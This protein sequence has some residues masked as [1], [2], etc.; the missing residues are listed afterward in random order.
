MTRISTRVRLTARNLEL[1][2]DRPG[3]GAAAREINAAA[4]ETAKAIIK[5]IGRNYRQKNVSKPFWDAYDAILDPVLSK[6]RK[7]G[8]QDTEPRAACRSYLVAKIAKRYDLEQ[9][10]EDQLYDTIY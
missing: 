9:W 1:Y 10:E 8:A 4:K 6:H 3:V 7:L 5:G 2:Q